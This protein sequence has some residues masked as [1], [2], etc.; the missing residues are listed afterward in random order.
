MAEASFPSESS[1]RGVPSFE[2][3]LEH[4]AWLRSLARHLV[5]DAAAAEDLVQETWLAAVRRPPVATRPV[6]PWLASV[7]R[8]LAAFAR[9]GEGRRR[10]REGEQPAPGAAPSTDELVARAEL[11][12]RLVERVLA[13]REPSRSAVLLCYFEGLAPSEAAREIGVPAATMRSRLK[14][15]L[16]ELRAQFEAERRDSGVDWRG[17]FAVFAA[18]TGGGATALVA[19]AAAV[20]LVATTAFVAWRSSGD[21]PRDD[22]PPVRVAV[23]S[24]EEPERFA[25]ETAAVAAARVLESPPVVTTPNDATDATVNEV[26]AETE[27][28][29]PVS[30]IRGRVLLPDGSLVGHCTID[31]RYLPARGHGVISVG[32]FAGQ[33]GDFTLPLPNGI[34]SPASSVRMYAHAVVDGR[35]LSRT[36]DVHVVSKDRVE[37]RLAEAPQLRVRVLDKQRAPVETYRCIAPD[38]WQNYGDL[39]WKD[40]V[41]VRSMTNSQNLAS[42]GGEIEPHPEGR[43]VLDLPRDRFVVVVDAPG[44][45][46]GVAGPFTVEPPLAPPS[47]DVEVVLTREIPIAGR[48]LAAGRPVEGAIV[49][50]NAVPK[51]ECHFEMDGLVLAVDPWNGQRVT[52][53]ADGS[54]ALPRIKAPY[55][56]RLSVIAKDLA[57]SEITIA[58]DRIDRSADL[59]VVLGPGGTLIGT[60]TGIGRGVRS[61]RLQ[62]DGPIVVAERRDLWPRTA[63]IDADG[64]FRIEHLTPG[65]WHVFL[66]K[67]GAI[68]EGVDFGHHGSG[69]QKSEPAPPTVWNV[70]IREGGETSITLE[71]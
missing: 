57:R 25:L 56:A 40:D 60:V 2:R 19:K 66:S 41:F 54:F 32:F 6:Q 20:F 18:R 38:S 15:A 70:E 21:G 33:S 30:E 5:D 12:R 4:A 22:A 14:R 7:A 45:V 63:R 23:A 50:V 16:D 53:G 37:I 28:P 27:E 43:C 47:R 29:G 55:G 51:P 68:L 1:D 36:V 46:R 17:A 31:Y 9:R 48:V 42:L 8:R 61:D 26:A 34:D 11:Q 13:L 62:E 49:A 58:A 64:K 39:E 71:R 65:P 44:Y 52:T 10:R 3:L 35:S 24:S 69:G 67:N 59:E